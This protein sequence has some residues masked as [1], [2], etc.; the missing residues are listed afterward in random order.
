MAREITLINTRAISVCLMPS[1][2]KNQKARS[3]TQLALSSLSHPMPSK[4]GAGPLAHRNGWKRWISCDHENKSQ[5]S[6]QE[7]KDTDGLQLVFLW[8]IDA[9][10]GNTRRGPRGAYPPFF[11][12]LDLRL[13]NSFGPCPFL[14]PF[15]LPSK[16]KFTF[17]TAVG[18]WVLILIYFKF[19]FKFGT[20]IRLLTF[21]SGGV[22]WSS[23]KWVLID[24][25]VAMEIAVTAE[26]KALFHTLPLSGKGLWDILKIV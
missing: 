9:S 20:C 22:F 13:E 17:V 5:A 10:S 26:T 12:F 11:S 8:V 23:M 6:K 7:E 2:W 19:W 24:R 25:H 16:T 1:P 18:V 21:I 3:S 15:S 14:P 4:W